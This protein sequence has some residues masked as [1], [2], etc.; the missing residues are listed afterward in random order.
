[1]EVFRSLI[2]VFI[3]LSCPPLHHHQ[4]QRQTGVHCPARKD[5]GVIQGHGESLGGSQL[6]LMA[7]AG[8]FFKQISWL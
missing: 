1:M 6:T 3:K 5:A 2:E 7:G 8:L 4:I